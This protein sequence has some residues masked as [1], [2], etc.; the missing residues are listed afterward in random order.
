M[1]CR[2]QAERKTEAWPADCGRTGGGHAPENEPGRAPD[3]GPQ[4]PQAA[5]R[6]DSGAVEERVPARAIASPHAAGTFDQWWPNVGGFAVGGGGGGEGDRFGPG[7]Q[8]AE[9]GRRDRS[10]TDDRFVSDQRD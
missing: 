10:P 1:V 2:I 5:V 8:K 6:G 7:T 9:R 4:Q 3:A